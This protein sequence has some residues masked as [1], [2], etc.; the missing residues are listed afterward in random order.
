[1]NPGSRQAAA[2]RRPQAGDH[3]QQIAGLAQVVL[4]LHAW[5]GGSWSVQTRPVRNS[6]RWQ[7][8]RALSSISNPIW[9]GAGTLGLKCYKVQTAAWSHCCDL[10]S[11]ARCVRQAAMTDSL[12]LK[13]RQHG[14]CQAQGTTIETPFTHLVPAAAPL[15]PYW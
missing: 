7:Q 10:H 2:G 6:V 8:N 11:L 5:A 1:M 3:K 4:L 15:T 9:S 12:S 13:L 14:A